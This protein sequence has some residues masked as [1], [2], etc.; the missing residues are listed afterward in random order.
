M[1]QSK[2]FRR[3]FFSYVVIIAVSMALYSA[4]LIYQSRRIAENQSAWEHDLILREVSDIM[5]EVLEDSRDTIR[6]IT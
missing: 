2:L 1:F 3:M 4:S 6:D 5:N